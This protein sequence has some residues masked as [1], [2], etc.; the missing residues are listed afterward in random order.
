MLIELSEYKR[1]VTLWP[2]SLCIDGDVCVYLCVRANQPISSK[3]TS[4]HSSIH[5]S[6]HP[7]S[8]GSDKRTKKR[9]KNRWKK[10]E[11]SFEKVELFLRSG[12]MK[13]KKS[14]EGK[15][16]PC[17]SCTQ[18]YQYFLSEVHRCDC[19]LTIL[20]FHYTATVISAI[21]RMGVADDNNKPGHPRRK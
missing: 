18:N 19:E 11:K 8:Q 21:T 4:A 12:G 20:S 10:L 5:P 3:L 9:Q 17:W 15:S 1:D 2:P 16:S 7:A 6:S 13:K 14:V